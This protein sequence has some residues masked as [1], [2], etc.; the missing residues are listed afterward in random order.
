MSANYYM[1]VSF[2]PVA[3]P[4]ELSVS[5]NNAKTKAEKIEVARALGEYSPM[6]PFVPPSS[7]SKLYGSK[8]AIDDLPAPI[9]CG[10]YKG[11]PSD[12][13]FNVFN[14]GWRSKNLGC[15]TSGL[16]TDLADAEIWLKNFGD[17]ELDLKNSIIYFVVQIDQ[18]S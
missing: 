12:S 15:R 14:N 5:F 16:F 8:G 10:V 18:H 13:P 17:T 3:N 9:K 7:G 11:Y 4:E 6:S 2:V 1:W